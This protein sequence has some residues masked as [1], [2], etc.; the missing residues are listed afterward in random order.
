M[1]QKATDMGVLVEWGGL[2]TQSENNDNEYLNMKQMFIYAFIPI[3]G[4]HLYASIAE[5][6]DG[7]GIKLA[8]AT[9]IFPEI[10]TFFWIRESHKQNV[11]QLSLP[12][13]DQQIEQSLGQIQTQAHEA[14]IE[15]VPQVLFFCGLCAFLLKVYFSII[16]FCHCVAV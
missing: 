8:L 3:F 14:C 11:P 10:R 5:L 16:V 6:I 4:H 1:Q 15:S 13:K 2:A 7:N 9:L 12:I